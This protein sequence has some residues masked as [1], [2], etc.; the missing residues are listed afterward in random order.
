MDVTELNVSFP[1]LEEQP[2]QSAE[3]TAEDNNH[4][5]NVA[6]D[7]AEDDN[8]DSSEE[9]DDEESSEG[10]SG[11]GSQTA[12]D[13]SSAAMDDEGDEH[14]ETPASSADENSTADENEAIGFTPVNET[15]D[16]QQLSRGKAALL[17]YYSVFGSLHSLLR[18]ATRHSSDFATFAVKSWHTKTGTFPP[19]CVGLK[20]DDLLSAVREDCQALRV[21]AES[22]EFMRDAQQLPAHIG[23]DIVGVY[24]ELLVKFWHVAGEV[25]LP[26]Y[27]ATTVRLVQPQQQK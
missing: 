6:A 8:N 26:H 16:Q 7:S 13:D 22:E 24:V 25:V 15:G 20:V 18:P 4:S 10:E 21:Y 11:S 27:G 19:S 5:S 1:A 12:G 14:V 17:G 3:T 23:E 2:Q 9:S